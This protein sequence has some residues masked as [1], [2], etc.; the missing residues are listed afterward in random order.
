VQQ[1]LEEARIYA[2]SIVD[3][4]REPLL[5]LDA[6]QRIVSAN[7]SFYQMFQVTREDTEGCLIY[8][9]G[10]H[11]WDI[12]RLRE[13]L[14][15]I[16]PANAHFDDYEVD[17]A[18][19]TIGHK[20]MLLNAR[21]L[22]RRGGE[23]WLILLAIED[24][25]DRRRAD[26]RLAR[27]AREMERSNADLQ[28]FATVA[29]HDLQE[30]LRKIQFFGEQLTIE[31]AEALGAEGRDY[32]ERMRNAAKRMQRLISDLLALA[33]ISTVGQPFVPV[34][35][36]EVT[37]NVVSDLEVQIEQLGARL[38]LGELPTVEA[39]PLQ[40]RQ[41]LQNLIDNALKFHQPDEAPVVKIHGEL[42]GVREGRPNGNPPVAKSCRVVVE[43]NGVGFDEKY[44]DRIFNV[45]Q[46]LSGRGQHEG[47]GMGLA[48]CRRIL[49]RHAGQIS[50]K[51][52]PGQGSTFVV[53]LPVV[54][55][56]EMN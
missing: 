19:P 9:L 18:F 16:V 10:N 36:A 52:R 47:T 44:L 28:E 41:L 56:K 21:R 1:A 2:D 53:T 27:L 5:V 29:A 11:Q 15:T 55:A 33:R 32:L 48:I 50:A 4:L 39:D 13:L 30:P 6:G 31:C 43:D 34:D 26:A 40:M 20:T 22:E 12:P 46:R 45:F 3:T 7:R 25:T 35:L 38:H 8:E 17:H 51:S 42:L 14:D 37:R 23:P 54:H 24:I 49:E